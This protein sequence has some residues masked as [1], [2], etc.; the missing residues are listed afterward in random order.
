MSGSAIE[1]DG[2]AFVGGSVSVNR[3]PSYV[4][5][6]WK[7]P[8]VVSTRVSCPCTSRQSQF[9]IGKPEHCGGKE[10]RSSPRQSSGP[11]DLSSRTVPPVAYRVG[12]GGGSGTRGVV[13]GVTS[14]RCGCPSWP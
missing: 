14:T 11:C 5:T 7:S 6:T 9:V 2:C 10:S 8:R 1:D 13:L 3:A 12:A 4:P